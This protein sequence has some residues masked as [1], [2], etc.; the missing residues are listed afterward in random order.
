MKSFLTGI[1]NV[2][3]WSYQ[4]GSWQYDVLCLIIVALI[5][6]AP[7]RYFGDRDRLPMKKANA[8]QKIASNAGVTTFELKSTDL[9]SFL[10][11]QN[12]IELMNA[13]QEAIVLY[14]RTQLKH[15]VEHIEYE[16]FKNPQ[17]QIGYRVRFK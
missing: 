13:P 16:Q 6:L 9:E 7:S 15:D 2:L 11:K 3:L 12:K 10:Q 14:I 8:A 4:R 17:G 5:F 1:K